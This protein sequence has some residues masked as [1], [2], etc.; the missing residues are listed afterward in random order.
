VTKH[1]VTRVD[2][3]K[4]AKVLTVLL[5]WSGVAADSPLD[6]EI[7]SNDRG[8]SITLEDLLEALGIIEPIANG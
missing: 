6:T 5:D 2:A 3:S 1:V 4:V 7:V 8:E